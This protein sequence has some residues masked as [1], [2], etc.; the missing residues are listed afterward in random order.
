MQ[1]KTIQISKKIYFLENSLFYDTR[2]HAYSNKKKMRKKKRMQK[3]PPWHMY[4][5]LTVLYFKQL[6]EPLFKRLVL[7]T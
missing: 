1:F 2:L 7:L 3:I 6:S 5:H 4:D